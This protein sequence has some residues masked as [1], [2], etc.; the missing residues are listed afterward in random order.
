MELQLSSYIENTFNGKLPELCKISCMVDGIKF[1]ISAKFINE[2]NVSNVKKL[3]SYVSKY[4]CE[5]ITARISTNL[6]KDL[7][8]NSK[9]EITRPC[10]INARLQCTSLKI[11]FNEYTKNTDFRNFNWNNLS[12]ETL[13]ISNYT[14]IT[15]LFTTVNVLPSIL[16]LIVHGPVINL[17]NVSYLKYF[18]QLK[19]LMNKNTIIDLTSILSRYNYEQDCKDMLA[20]KQSS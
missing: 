10:N 3:F 18:P 13:E 4:S 15:T 14:I 11:K 7:C 17:Y 6:S 9:V 20:K 8:F 5:D 1:V 19:Q 12:T 2:G 16:N